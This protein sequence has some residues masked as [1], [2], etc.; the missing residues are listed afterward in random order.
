MA[1]ILLIDDE[2][3]IRNVL[4]DILQHE[5]YRIEE[6]ADGEQGL[7]KLAAQPFDLV[8]CDI[9]MPKMDG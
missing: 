4:K 8:L 2:K 5:G 1:A 3:S 7:Q 6:A 9:K